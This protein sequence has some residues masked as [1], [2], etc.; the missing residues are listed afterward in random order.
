MV[1]VTPYG[2]FSTVRVAEN[3]FLIIST[4]RDIYMYDICVVYPYNDLEG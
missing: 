4:V 2:L 1:P 3:G